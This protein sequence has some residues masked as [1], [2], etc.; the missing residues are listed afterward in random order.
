MLLFIHDQK[1]VLKHDDYQAIK[2]KT[3]IL[4]KKTSCLNCSCTT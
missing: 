4:V 1:V 3:K 2:I